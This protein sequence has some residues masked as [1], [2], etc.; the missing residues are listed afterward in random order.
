MTQKSKL[1]V[2]VNVSQSI[3]LPPVLESSVAIPENVF[4][5]FPANTGSR[6]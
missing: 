5:F 6:V 2:T 1:L 4:D 3:K